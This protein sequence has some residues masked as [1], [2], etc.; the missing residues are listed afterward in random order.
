LACNT[1]LVHALAKL[2]AHLVADLIVVCHPPAAPLRVVQCLQAHAIMQEMAG[3]WQGDG[4][5][6]YTAH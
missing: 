4:R 3:R 5:E 1:S 6:V 2:A